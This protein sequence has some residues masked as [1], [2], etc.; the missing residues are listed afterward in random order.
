MLCATRSTPC[1]ALSE[2]ICWGLLSL[3]SNLCMP[4]R[5]VAEPVLHVCNYWAEIDAWA[6]AACSHWDFLPE[7]TVEAQC[8]QC[9]KAPWWSMQWLSIHDS[10]V[11]ACCTPFSNHPASSAMPCMIELHMLKY[12]VCGYSGG[13]LHHSSVSNQ[14]A[15]RACSHPVQDPG[16][17]GKRSAHCFCV[18]RI[19]SLGPP[20]H[21]ESSR[22]AF[23]GML[24][25][26]L[27]Q[28]WCSESVLSSS[29][30][31]MLCGRHSSPSVI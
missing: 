5:S 10:R 22:V 4:G 28:W 14:G 19:V 7:E 8:C 30:K 23:H 25:V 24:L 17:H 15:E 13:T 20:L 9:A 27:C 2:V 31:C 6:Q 29:V 16:C 21:A 12:D 26:M 3:E 18:C 1:I 11:S